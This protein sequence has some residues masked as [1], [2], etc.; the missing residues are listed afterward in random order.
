[1]QALRRVL[2]D[3]D[4]DHEVDALGQSILRRLCLNG[5]EDLVA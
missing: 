3:Y 5:L 4:L 1:V 2:S